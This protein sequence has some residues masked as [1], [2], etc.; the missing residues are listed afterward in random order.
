MSYLYDMYVKKVHNNK[1]L[2]R[3][4][5]GGGGSNYLVQILSVVYFHLESDGMTR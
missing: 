5:E 3:E 4:R 1:S 2:V